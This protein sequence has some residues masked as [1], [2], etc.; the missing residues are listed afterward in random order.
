MV[1]ISAQTRA[2][3]ARPGSVCLK[4]NPPVTNELYEID[5]TAADPAAFD[6]AY[7]C[8]LI[9]TSDNRLLVQERGEEFLTYPGRITPFGGRVE[10]NESSVQALQRE[11]MEE[12]GTII[13]ASELQYIGSV[14]KKTGK[15]TELIH[16][17]FWHDKM[18]EI[19]NCYEGSRL[20]L[21]TLRD[22]LRFKD[23]LMPGL[24]WL[25]ERCRHLGYLPHLSK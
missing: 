22:F 3:T 12:L 2:P 25:F 13:R 14:V 24:V 17:Y 9:M 21:Y 10:Q 19:K 7:S 4:R 20:Y 16:T 5:I 15:K 6:E 23:R 1:A 18:D 8:C 11:I